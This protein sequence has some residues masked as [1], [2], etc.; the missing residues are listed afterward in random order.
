MLNGKVSKTSSLIAEA[1][2][3]VPFPNLDHSLQISVTRFDKTPIA[4]KAVYLRDV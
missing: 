3:L 1:F 4:N 2:K